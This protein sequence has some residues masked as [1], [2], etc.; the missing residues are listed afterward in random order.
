MKKT[1]NSQKLVEPIVADYTDDLVLFA[2][3]PT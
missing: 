1:I 2:N 3:I